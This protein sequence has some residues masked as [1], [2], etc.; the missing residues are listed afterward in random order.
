[1]I[2]IFVRRK[3][4]PLFNIELRR[5]NVLIV[6]FGSWGWRFR[7]HGRTGTIDTV[8]LARSYRPQY[9]AGTLSP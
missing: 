2:R 8:Y 6:S 1:V 7:A 3:L 9:R 5:V 4:I